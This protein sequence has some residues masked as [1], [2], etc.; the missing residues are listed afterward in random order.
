MK[1]IAPSKQF[2]TAA[3]KAAEVAAKFADDVDA[4]GRFPTEAMDAIKQQRL[5]SMM[6]PRDL[7]G[8]GASLAQVAQVCS[9][10]SK[11][12]ASTGMIFGMHQIKF[13]SLLTHSGDSAWH[14]NFMKDIADKQLLLGSATT[15][16]GI[17]GD[18][19]NSICAV[20]V[21]GGTARLTKD[22]TVISYGEDCD[23]ILVT[24]RKDK[25]AASND[26][27]MIVATKDQY[28]LEK[29]TDWNTLGMRGTRSLG[30]MFRSE[31][32]AEQIFAK[33]FAEIAAQSMLACAHIL[34]SSIW[35]GIANGAMARAQAFAKGEAKKAPAGSQPVA[36]LR[37]AEAMNQLHLM[38]A[39]VVDAIARFERARKNEDDLNSVGFGVAMLNVKVASSQMVVDIVSRCMLICGIAGYRNDT[40]FSL[41]RYLRDAHSAP[42]MISN[43]R[44]Y[45]NLGNSLLVG[46]LDAPLDA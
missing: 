38:R 1:P 42:I 31:F 18:L 34:W 35:L 11:A 30:Y 19:R 16:T 7:G 29:T 14:R 37:L 44:I 5:L 6:V 32:P 2:E 23:A 41:G 40:P 43:N 46:R 3:L 27:V 9:I 20:E 12:C 4:T 25:D 13:T 26:Q 8:N 10:L 28:T 39:N 36:V 22:A 15:E 45:S 24:A 21:E 17:G 33:P